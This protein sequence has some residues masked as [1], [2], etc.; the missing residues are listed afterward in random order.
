[1]PILNMKT[2]TFSA[3]ALAGLLA[4]AAQSAHAASCLA[5]G[6]W[7]SLEQ[8]SPAAVPASTLIADM[9][10]R[11][12]VLLGEFHDEDDHHRWQVHTLASLHVVRPNMVIGF[13]MFP[14]RVQPVLDRW[15]AGELTLKQFLEQAEWEKVW[16]TP[17][18]LY[19]PLF[20]FA[21]INRI[22]MIALNVD[23]ALNKAVREKGWDQVPEAQREG[24]GRPAAPPEAYRDYLF[25][26]YRMHAGAHGP[27]G[28]KPAKSDAGFRH[29]VESQ[30][31]WDR[32]MA[33]A[34]AKPLRAAQGADKPLAVAILGAAHA[35]YGYGVPHQLRDLGVKDSGILVAMPADTECKELRPGMANAVFGLPLQVAEKP[36]PPRLGVRLEE[37]DGGVRL[38]EV[39]AGSLAERTGLKAG[40]R[41]LEI[42]GVA[43]LK[44]AQVVKAVRNQPPGSWLPVRI[45]RG[46]ESLDMVIKFPV[47]S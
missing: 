40:D 9:A 36:E 13:E 32:A 20:Q 43:A 12:V 39:T 3:A 15:V 5:A 8:R 31:T 2:S 25:D 14:R 47:K 45:K 10:R 37:N 30:T 1:M 27:K 19:I 21:R 11:D 24:V 35:Q 44:S 38:T 34:L 42:G 6:A 26:V 16:N 18:D 17:P 23:N 29:F 4:L 28:G 33:E 46:D 41:L 7:S 22:P